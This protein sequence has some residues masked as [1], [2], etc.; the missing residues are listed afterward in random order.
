MYITGYRAGAKT[1]EAILAVKRHTGKSVSEAKKLIEDAIEGKPVKLP[2]D[3]VLRE[4]LE[5]LGFR[6]N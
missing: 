4:E 5:D 6:L 3:F 1:I 2:D